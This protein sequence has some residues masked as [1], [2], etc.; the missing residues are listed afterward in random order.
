MFPRK[1]WKRSAVQHY[2]PR[3]AAR[4]ARKTPAVRRYTP[5]HSRTRRPD[6]PENSV[7][8][9]LCGSALTEKL[10]LRCRKYGISPGL[11][12]LPGFK[13]GK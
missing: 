6:C 2:A 10:R 7:S 1:R 3:L 8:V 4:I 5:T 13:F 9:L 11:A 12:A